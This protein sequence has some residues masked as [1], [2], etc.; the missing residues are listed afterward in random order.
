MYGDSCRMNSL[1][2]T[3]RGRAKGGLAAPVESEVHFRSDIFTHNFAHNLSWTKV[4]KN[5][6][7][8]AYFTEYLF[9]SEL[10][11]YKNINLWKNLS[12]LF[13]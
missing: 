10:F 12:N 7:E 13:N 1:G 4:Q 9:W 2:K 6:F 11:F 8:K 5:Q 3:P